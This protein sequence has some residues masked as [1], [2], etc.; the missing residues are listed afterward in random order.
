MGLVRTVDP[1]ELAVALADARKQCEI[2]QSDTTHDSHL[3]R[4]IRAAT[5]DVER[6]TRRALVTQTWRLSLNDWPCDSTHYRRYAGYSGRILLPRPPLQSVT[7]ITYVNDAGTVET[8]DPSAYQVAVDASPAY[9]EPA[10]GEV[11]PTVRPETVETI[12]VTY[13]AGFG[14]DESEIPEQYKGLV[15]ELVA[16]RFMNRGDAETDIPKHIKW[17]LD[18]LKCGARYDYYGIKN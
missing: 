11:W 7:S 18:A 13:V 9:V 15:C 14:A 8:I 3:T 16:F 1:V 4:L 17:S 10:Y 2:G 6:Y 5:A 12:K